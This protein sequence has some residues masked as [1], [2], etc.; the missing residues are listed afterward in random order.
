MYDVFMRKVPEVALG[1]KAV[2]LVRPGRGK[3]LSIKARVTFGRFGWSGKPAEQSPWLGEIHFRDGKPRVVIIE[4]DNVVKLEERS[5]TGTD[6]SNDLVK[7]GKADNPRPDWPANLPTFKFLNAYVYYDDWKES[8]FNNTFLIRSGLEFMGVTLPDIKFGWNGKEEAIFR[9][10]IFAEGVMAGASNRFYYKDKGLFF[11]DWN[12]DLNDAIKQGSKGQ[13]CQALVEKLFKKAAKAKFKFGLNPPEDKTKLVNDERLHLTP[14]GVTDVWSRLADE[15]ANN[16]LHI[17]TAIFKDPVMFGKPFA[18]AGSE[19][20]AIETLNHFVKRLKQVWELAK[21]IK[22]LLVAGE[23][24]AAFIAL[25]EI[26]EVVL[27]LVILIPALITLIK[28]LIDLAADNK[29]DKSKEDITELKKEV[30]E[31][32]SQLE[33]DLKDLAGDTV[34]HLFSLGGAFVRFADGSD[35][36]VNVTWSQMQVPAAKGNIS[37]KATFATNDRFKHAELF[38]YPTATPHPFRPRILTTSSQP[39]CLFGLRPTSHSD[40]KTAD[41]DDITRTGHT[42]Q[43]VNCN[44]VASHIAEPPAPINLAFRITDDD[45][46]QTEVSWNAAGTRHE[47]R[48]EARPG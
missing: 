45:M 30:E 13:P 3:R 4:Y 36:T 38:P 20:L 1:S 28:Y 6:V 29:D 24:V 32:H 14:G 40:T 46:R 11:E 48:T 19:K 33:K 9:N 37:F 7:T 26:A 42:S 18:I 21:E 41:E 16:I 27:P 34:T 15:V 5:L 43:H 31:H 10:V 23:V 47:I 44:I 2:R 12:A 22:D 35:D 8:S 39:K 17:E 25:I